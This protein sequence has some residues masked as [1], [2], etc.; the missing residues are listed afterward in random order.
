MESLE[1][2]WGDVGCRSGEMSDDD[3]DEMRSD[4]REEGEDVHQDRMMSMTR[5]CGRCDE[6][7]DDDHCRRGCQIQRLTAFQAENI[8]G[9]WSGS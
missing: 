5:C 4:E 3:I 9:V 7:D 6:H 2:K 8:Y 1:R